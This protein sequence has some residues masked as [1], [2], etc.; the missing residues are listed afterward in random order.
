[1]GKYIRYDVVVIKGELPAGGL[2]SGRGEGGEI[3]RHEHRSPA[4]EDDVRGSGFLGLAYS[5]VSVSD[6]V[7]VETRCTSFCVLFLNV[8]ENMFNVKITLIMPFRGNIVQNANLNPHEIACFLQF[9]KMYTPENN[10]VHG[11]QNQDTFRDNSAN[12][13][14]DTLVRQR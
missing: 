4:W 2:L 11:I 10:Y 8:R 6:T 13:G 5:H 3:G 14:L 12:T 1:M 9:A 7:N